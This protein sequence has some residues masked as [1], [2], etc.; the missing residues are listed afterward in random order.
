MFHCSAGVGRTGTFIVIDTMLRRL[1]KERDVDVFGCV[2]LLRTQRM[3][4]VQTVVRCFLKPFLFIASHP[5]T[6]NDRQL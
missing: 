3:Q 2:S 6:L 1:A 5:A 4:M